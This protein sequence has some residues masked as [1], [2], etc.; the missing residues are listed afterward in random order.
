[1][2]KTE[3]ASLTE[4]VDEE[5]K[6]EGW[7]D[8]IRDHGK[9]IFLDVRDRSGIVQVV[10][11][12]KDVLSIATK[13]NPEDL[14]SITGVVQ[15]R[16]DKLVN[17]HLA[18]GTIEIGASKIEIISNSAPL[19]FEVNQNTESIS[20][21]LRFKYRYL[22]L[23][24]ERM[25]N[26]LMFRHKL[27]HYFRNALEAHGFWEIE[28]PS[29]T[30]GTPE[31]AREY[32]VPSRQQEGKFFVLPQSPQQFKQ[33][34]MVGGIEK[35]Y[36]IARCFRDEDQRG[37]RQP[38]FTQLDIEMSFITQEDILELIESMVIGL[39]KEVFPD[40]KIASTPF[41][42]ITYKESMEKYNSDK[43]DIRQD[44]NNQDELAF[45]WVVDFP[46]FEY[47]D[48]EKKYIANHH[49]FTRP[50][51]E[52]IPL[53]TEK[54]ETARAA[55]YDLVLNG[56][57]IGGGSIRI[58]EEELQKKIFEILGLSKEEAETRFGH[59]LTAFT[60]SPPPHGG[61][62]FGIDRLLTILLNQKSIR[63]VI[64]FPKT[65]DAKDPLT[66]APDFVSETTLREAHIKTRR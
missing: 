14:V 8:S 15:K 9:V 31:G 25:K 30:K 18:T 7:I 11:F 10:A 41:P 5:I 55:A 56:S 46:M 61:F 37:D 26:N 57:E 23:R 17:T 45:L 49:P 3:I 6:F 33:L 21:L 1:M 42:R 66:G 24:S 22:D 50:L 27:N 4:S 13:L 35:Y 19:P 28:T 60:F 63:E 64:A 40:K 51:D 20:E 65:G 2:A 48:N 62:A 34:L 36:Q 29:L 44:K 32:I 53:L 12:N 38:E 54:P 52:D 43:P 59:M 39:V 16:P 47:S 58:H